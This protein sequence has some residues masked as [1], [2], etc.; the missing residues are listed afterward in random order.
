MLF[1]IIYIITLFLGGF[2]ILNTVLKIKELSDIVIFSIPVGI[3]INVPLYFLFDKLGLRYD[4][5][6]LFI[7]L[8]LYIVIAGICLYKKKIK[9]INNI[10]KVPWYFIIF[11]TFILS[12][13]I[14][15]AYTS[16]FNWSNWD[17]FSAWQIAPKLASIDNSYDTSITIAVN[18]PLLVVNG[19]LVNNI[20]GITINYARIFS[21]IFFGLLLI[22][23]YFELVRMKVNRNLAAIVTII[24]ATS[25][26]ELIILSKTYYNNIF[27]TFYFTTGLW[28]LAKQFLIKYSRKDLILSSI[29]LVATILLR[30]EMFI[31]NILAYILMFII[32]L[33]KKD[34]IFY[35]LKIPFLITTIAY[36]FLNIIL[37]PYTTFSNLSLIQSKAEIIERF[38]GPVLK[39]FIIAIYEQ[40]FNF[41]PYY[42]YTTVYIFVIIA[43][44]IIFVF[45]KNIIKKNVNIKI[46]MYMYIIIVQ[47]MYIGLILAT[48]FVRFKRFEFLVAASFSRYVLLVLPF[49][50]LILGVL[51][52]DRH[53]EKKE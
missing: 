33:I 27:C 18:T 43:V 51:I 45:V 2:L 13:L 25:A 7:I 30:N 11:T 38:S 47:C 53:F 9:I 48:Q 19:V 12:N 5:I 1:L 15:A 42:I 31:F 52:N 8:F 20:C 14:I 16:Y 49:S 26:P 32:L 6:T 28:I 22:F 3:L 34:K 23:M 35:K 21:S 24:F 40:M 44:I 29:L 46:Q 41:S 39:Q 36:I 17:E 4:R 50:F 37:K 10:N